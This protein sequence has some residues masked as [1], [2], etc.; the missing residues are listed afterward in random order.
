MKVRT[1]ATNTGWI[2]AN[3]PLMLVGG[4]AVSMPDLAR[5]AHLSAA[6]ARIAGLLEI[7][8]SKNCLARATADPRVTDLDVLH[9]LQVSEADW[10]VG[11]ISEKTAI[12]N[13]TR[14]LDGLCDPQAI[15][16]SR[17][18]ARPQEP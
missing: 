8:S 9:Q 11:R 5:Q 15:R 14:L 2:F 10:K 7:K 13:R 16:A 1:N 6:D 3:I 17:S 4:A 18:E 12:V